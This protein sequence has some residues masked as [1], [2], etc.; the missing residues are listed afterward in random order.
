ML[1]IRAY[2][3]STLLALLLCGCA[4]E[5]AMKENTVRRDGAGT[6]TLTDAPKVS[7]AVGGWQA[8]DT[9]NPLLLTPDLITNAML[10]V[11]R[12][13]PGEA[14]LADGPDIPAGLDTDTL[15]SLMSERVASKGATSIRIHP[16]GRYAVVVADYQKSADGVL[17]QYREYAFVLNGGVVHLLLVAKPGPYYASGNKVAEKVI[18][19]L[20][21]G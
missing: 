17:H 7:F 21:A 14:L 2:L 20:V 10:A 11:S 18:E 13:K 12:L 3:C 4:S 5:P 6:I 9:S 19:S 16:M 8:G 15:K 1:S